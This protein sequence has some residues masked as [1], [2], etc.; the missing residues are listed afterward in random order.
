MQVGNTVV[1]QETIAPSTATNQNV[2]WHS[3]RTLVATVNSGLVT[4]VSPG[5]ARVTVSVG[6]QARYCDF[7]VT[8]VATTGIKLSVDTDELNDLQVV[9]NREI[10]VNVIM[11]PWNATNKT[12]VW[13]RGTENST[14]SDISLREEN[15]GMV[16][17][18][19]SL[20]AAGLGSLI[21]TQGS[22]TTTLWIE[23]KSSVTNSISAIEFNTYTLSLP[24]GARTTTLADNKRITPSSAAGGTLIWKSS[25]PS[26]A[27]VNSGT[28]EITAVAVGP[29]VI[30]ATSID[31]GV[32]QSCNVTVRAASSGTAVT[33][34]TMQAAYNQPD[35]LTRQIPAL[36]VLP[37]NATNKQLQWYVS[38]PTKLTVSADGQL[39]SLAATTTPVTVM[40]TTVDGGFTA[41][42]LVNITR[43]P[44]TG[45]LL[46]RTQL[47]ELYVGDTYNLSAIIQPSNASDTSATWSS[48]NTAIVTVS[49]SGLTGTVTGL[50]AGQTMITVTTNATDL[51]RQTAT[52]Q[53]VVRLFRQERLNVTPPVTFRM[54]APSSEPSWSADQSQHNVTLTQGFYMSKYLVTQ[55]NYQDVMALAGG[56]NSNP[57][58][59]TSS[60]LTAGEVQVNRPVDS[61]S[62][63]DALVFCNTLSVLEGLSPAYSING[64]T[65][66]WG[67]AP[68]TQNATWD[69]VTVVPGSTGYRLPT[70]A[71]WEY[72]CRAGSTTA[73]SLGS[74]WS[75]D[76]GWV[77]TNSN[78]RSHEVGKKAPNAWGLYDMHGNVLEWC[79]DRYGSTY[80]Q[81]SEAR[82]DPTGP[83]SGNNRV[84][85]G[86][87][88]GAASY[89]RSASRTN[90]EPFLRHGAVGLRV[91]RPYVAN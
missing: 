85:R 12:I 27:T 34:V 50:K 2:T 67:A 31:T 45:V 59:G 72:A 21:A 73:W 7:T 65:S 66:A 41:T 25:N 29:T 30:T 42:C 77:S 24:V 36:Q 52:C 39:T 1:L 80:Y 64:S 44:V 22:F 81:S 40:A 15:D 75:D 63:Y 82:N 19:R 37:A 76:W 32:M 28:G 33:G 16:I 38:D 6:G 79:W 53:V 23:P 4:A 46:N 87:N 17:Y 83:A 43:V 3:S 69:A 60:T 35:K 78:N 51:P 58:A 89:A 5:T 61:V 90:F 74:T 70:E 88:W 84:T 18:V 86:G 55:Q 48:G 57:S 8:E 14:T 13:T 68:T 71:Q 20:R 49:G 91:V 9:I 47:V 11:E 54:G 56:V 10:R 26:A 62:W